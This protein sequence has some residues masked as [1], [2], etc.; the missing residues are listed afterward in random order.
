MHAWEQRRCMNNIIP[1]L[2]YTKIIQN[3]E[4]MKW[5]A[6]WKAWGFPEKD[7]SICTEFSEE[8]ARGIGIASHFIL[9]RN[10]GRNILKIMTL[11]NSLCEGAIGK[12]KK[13]RALCLDCEKTWMD[14]QW[15]AGQVQILQFSSSLWEALWDLCQPQIGTLHHIGFTTA[16]GRANH[17]AMAF[18]VQMI[19]LRTCQ[20]NEVWVKDTVAVL[21]GNIL[22]EDKKMPLTTL[23]TW[24]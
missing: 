8:A 12:T 20:K 22:L 1:M 9:L 13:E 3:K 14:S 17:I 18:T 24:V 16:L 19:I 15:W 4:K 10:S 6:Q 5:V 23:Y 11:R 21:L 7:M 2:S